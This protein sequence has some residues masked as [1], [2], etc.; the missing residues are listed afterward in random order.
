MSNSDWTKKYEPK[1]FDGYVCID[2]IR[3]IFNNWIKNGGVDTNILL[4]GTPGFG[5]TTLGWVLINTFAP[6]DY[7]YLDGGSIK[8]EQ[9]EN[10]VVNFIFLII[11]QGDKFNKKYAI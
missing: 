8:M 5:K 11:K 9:L 7:L 2:R 1:T 3:N 6:M 4:G 10:D